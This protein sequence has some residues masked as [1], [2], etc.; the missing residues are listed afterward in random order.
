MKKITWRYFTLLSLLF[1]GLSCTSSQKRDPAQTTA[2]KPKHYIMTLHGVRGDEKAFGD[3]HSLIK[4]HLEQIDPGIEVIP[5]NMT[6]KIAQVDY[7]Q[8][9]AAQEIGQKLI[10]M[11]PHIND[12]DKL[13]IIGY[14]MGGQVGLAWYF[15][16]LNTP[17]Q[18]PYADRL[19]HFIGLGSA[20]WGAKEAGLLTSDVNVLKR[21]IKFVTTEIR[22]ALRVNSEKYLG[23]TTTQGLIWMQGKTDNQIDAALAKLQTIDQIQTF[24]DSYIRTNSL[25]KISFN[26][27]KA[28]SWGGI[29]STDLRLG[30][31]ESPFKTPLVKNIK[32]TTI[33]PLVQ[34]FETDTGSTSAGCDDFQNSIFRFINDKVNKPYTFGYTRRET[35]NA[36][37]SPS[38]N[39]QFYSLLVYDANYPEAA[40]IPLAQTRYAIDPQQHQLYFTEALH[41]TLVTAEQ[42]NKV[43][44]KLSTLGKSWERLAGDVVVVYD[45]QCP[46]LKKCS[47]HPTYKYMVK[48]L[49]DCDRPNSTCSDIGRSQVL[50]VLF[51]EATE[52]TAQEKLAS[53]MHGFSLELNLRLPK[54]YDFSQIENTNILNYVQFDTTPA[55][56]YKVLRSSVSLPNYITIAREKEIGSVQIKK[57][58]DFSNQDQLKVSMTGLFIP[59]DSAAVY[60]YRA[61]Q[62][63]TPIQFKVQLPGMKSRIINTLVRPYHSTYVDLMMGKR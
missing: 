57:V 21:T 17:A 42:Y 30:L 55:K 3:F 16:A 22:D 49:A 56:D 53:E 24:Y 11:V 46:D 43:V 7:T 36:V 60:N 52:K 47:E 20:Y 58:T 51:H 9:K 18:K 62:K 35:D 40:E 5:L 33:L 48:A 15:D 6:F 27:F 59:N 45:S 34:C 41:A 50:D 28:L 23:K 14:S 8:K 37:I 32:W 25:V 12:Q 29:A 26:E 19:A 1:I 39:I 10:Q 63:G 13:S 38:G 61:L 44:N 54:G 2:V 31:L 4:K